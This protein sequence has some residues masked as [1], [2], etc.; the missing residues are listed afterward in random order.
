MELKAECREAN[1]ATAIVAQGGKHK[2]QDGIKKVAPK[3][4]AKSI[5]AIMGARKIA[6]RK[7]YNDDKKGCF[8]CKCTKPKKGQANK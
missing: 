1:Q 4:S 2:K 8:A 5:E 3:K 7:C 6:Y